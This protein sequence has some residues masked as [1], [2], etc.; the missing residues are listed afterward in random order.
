MPRF[1]VQLLVDVYHRF[2]I[3]LTLNY[4]ARVAKIAVTSFR[5]ITSVVVVEGGT[6]VEMPL[7]N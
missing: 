1:K 7:L 6:V 3:T 2:A 5:R 4:G